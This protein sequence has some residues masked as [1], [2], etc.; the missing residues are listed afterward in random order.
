MIE[1]QVQNQIDRLEDRFHLLTAALNYHYMYKPM[2]YIGER[3][4]I[5]QERGAICDA[6]NKIRGEFEGR[7]FRDYVVPESIEEK[8]NEVKPKLYNI[9]N[10]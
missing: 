7:T 3:I 4:C 10:L 5:N 9:Y 1:N 2:F 8:I 6:I